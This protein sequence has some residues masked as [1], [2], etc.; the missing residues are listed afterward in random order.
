[1]KDRIVTPFVRPLHETYV[2]DYRTAAGTVGG[3]VAVLLL[4]ACANVAAVML[5]RALARR[6]EMG[7]RLA[8]GSS[9]WR[10]LRQLLIEN[11]MLATAGGVLGLVAGRW[12][13]AA[14][15]T[16]I[17]DQLPRWAA[18]HMDLRVMAFSVAVVV[19]TVILFG[20]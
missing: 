13:L 15:V 6:R 2:E 4:I 16:A 9:R 20:W 17:P 14:L 8:L 18:F 19:G 10:L 1:D 11:V 12:A 3:A 5:A 7:I